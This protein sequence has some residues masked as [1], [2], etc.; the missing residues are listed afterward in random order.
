MQPGVH[1]F[2]RSKVSW[3]TL[4]DG[5]PAVEV[6]YDVDELWPPESLRRIGR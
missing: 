2:T 3:V 4:P 6:Y 1:I 5:V